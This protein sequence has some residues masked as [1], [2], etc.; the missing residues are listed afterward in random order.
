MEMWPV[1]SSA[2]L[3]HSIF[4]QG[5]HRRLIA[6]TLNRICISITKFFGTPF[7]PQVFG[8]AGKQL[9]VEIAVNIRKRTRTSTCKYTSPVH[10]IYIPDELEVLCPFSEIFGVLAEKVNYSQTKWKGTGRSWGWCPLSICYKRNAKNVNRRFQ[11]IF[12]TNKFF[13][14]IKN[15]FNYLA[16][17]K[18]DKI[19]LKGTFRR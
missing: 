5:S 7:Q 15:L 11:E 16:S 19:F 12:V 17:T 1:T 3:P 9:H 4:H 13:Q 14:K 8:R 18:P 2:H 6:N 10:L